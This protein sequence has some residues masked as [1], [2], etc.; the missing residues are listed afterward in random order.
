MEEKV[1]VALP[2]EKLIPQ[3]LSVRFD[4][5]NNDEAFAEL[6]DSVRAHGIIEPLLVRPV[7]DGNYEIVCGLRRFK[8]AE[9][10]GLKAVPCVVK[11][12]SDAEAMELV[13][14][15]NERRQ[16]L[17]DY[18][19]GRWL[20]LMLE[21]FPEKYSNQETLAKA[22]GKKSHLF[23]SRLIAHFE[24]IE[25]MKE[26]LPSNIVPRGT[27]LP[28]R[29]VR[30]IRRAPEEIKPKLVEYAV[31]HERSSRDVAGVVDALQKADEDVRK[32]IADLTVRE[33]LAPSQVEELV[34]LYKLPEESP[35]EALQKLK[36]ETKKRE[37]AFKKAEKKLLDLL[38]QSYPLSLLDDVAEHCGIGD[39]E[40]RIRN[41]LKTVIEVAWD[42]IR[43]LNLVEYVL[44]TADKWKG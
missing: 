38:S 40:S 24:E 9:K 34:E 11:S 22:I 1:A 6:A 8:A 16:N 36:E 10:A 37:E 12:V 5:T 25:R 29:V 14:I 31:K 23:V 15:E 26:A 27:M 4:E 19:M 35:E 17:S 28:E 18:E 3:S 39:S 7:A 41:Y 13:F 42:K 20:K 44:E 43:E 2:L 21:K 33:G 30:E 32:K